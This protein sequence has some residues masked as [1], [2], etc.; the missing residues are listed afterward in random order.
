[1]L[2]LASNLSR[3]RQFSPFRFQKALNIPLI[4][5]SF[6]KSKKDHRDNT[7]NQDERIM[8]GVFK[9]RDQNDAFHRA[10][11]ADGRRNDAVAD[12]QFYYCLPNR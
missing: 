3:A 10:E 8:P 9:A 2:S 12:Q 7:G 6:L 11:D 5:L 4:G 1:M